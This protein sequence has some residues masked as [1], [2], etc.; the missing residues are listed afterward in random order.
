MSD[1][2]NIG[3]LFSCL[4]TLSQIHK[5]KTLAKLRAY[6]VRDVGIKGEVELWSK[7]KNTPWLF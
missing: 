7:S 2:E 3:V 5:N 4:G 6:S 1:L